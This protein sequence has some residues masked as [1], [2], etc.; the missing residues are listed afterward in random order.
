M[1]PGSLEVTATWLAYLWAEEEWKNKQK[2]AQRRLP[3]EAELPGAA[4]R[5][6]EQKHAAATQ[7]QG[8][9][10]PDEGRGVPAVV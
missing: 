5:R 6:A 1:R 7:A 4:N 9:T 3:Q 2:P 10:R 8:P